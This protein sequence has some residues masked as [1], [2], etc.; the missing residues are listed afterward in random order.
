MRAWLSSPFPH[1]PTWMY[2]DGCV[3]VRVS[4]HLVQGRST[5]VVPPV[6]ANCAALPCLAWFL[7][8]DA[9]IT[10][11]EPAWKHTV[12]SSVRRVGRETNSRTSDRICSVNGAAGAGGLVCWFVQWVLSS[13]AVGIT[14]PSNPSI[15]P[16]DEGLRGKGGLSSSIGV[17]CA[18]VGL[19]KAK[20]CK[21]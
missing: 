21:C 6:A 15:S 18:C 3:C 5:V 4:F 16:S 1:H 10:H 2:D 11:Q 9:A 7:T 20:W 17:V 14:Y 12:H 8:R 13:V 19:G